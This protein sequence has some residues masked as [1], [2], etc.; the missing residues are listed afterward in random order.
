MNPCGKD[1][2]WMYMGIN[3]L[4]YRRGKCWYIGLQNSNRNSQDGLGCVGFT[5]IWPTTKK[6]AIERAKAI[7]DNLGKRKVQERV[8][9][10][11]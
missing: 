2:K 11:Y 7:F 9:Y 4:V 8:Q 3:W 10:G 5:G 6:H 1:Y